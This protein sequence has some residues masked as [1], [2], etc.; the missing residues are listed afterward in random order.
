[1]KRRKVSSSINTYTC[2]AKSQIKEIL[3]SFFPRSEFADNFKIEENIFI[4]VDELIK[5]AI[6]ANYKFILIV[7]K[8]YEEE[9]DSHPE[10]DEK[11]IWQNIW[12]ILRNRDA[13]DCAAEKI[14]EQYGLIDTVRQVLREESQLLRIKDRISL[15]E[16]EFTAEE[17]SVMHSLTLLGE[18][19]EKLRK[20]DVKVLLKIE[21]DD[22]YIFIEITNNAPILDEDLQRIY[23][24]RDEFKP[25]RTSGR[26]HEFFINN[27]DTSGGG[28]GLG[29]A[30]V[31]AS[32]QAA[33]YD[34]EHVVRIL[35]ASDT[36]VLVAIPLKEQS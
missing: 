3:K 25:Y 14:V 29:Y 13:F 22:E 21:D 15:S 30:V 33:N 12:S 36:T 31:D 7:D 27:L 23:E 20:N 24:K 19:K 17:Q 6:K 34:P 16:R 35:A 1:M 10:L 28:F 26:E 9:R 32:I 11:E 5:N 4:C 18:V 2:K 8:L